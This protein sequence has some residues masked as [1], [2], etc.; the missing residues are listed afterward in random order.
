SLDVESFKGRYLG[1]P[2]RALIAALGLHRRLLGR[3]HAG[4]VV[5]P[6]K[7][8]G[9]FSSVVLEID[10]LRGIGDR[11]AT[12]RSQFVSYMKLRESQR[13]ALAQRPVEAERTAVDSGFVRELRFLHCAERSER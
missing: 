9:R 7:S 12:C 6:R 5:C 3:R 2:I 13:R 1:G 11:L 10:T 8:L 4:K